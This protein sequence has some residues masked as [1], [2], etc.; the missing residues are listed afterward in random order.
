MP[1]TTQQADHHLRPGDR[2]LTILV[3]LALAASAFACSD[4]AA[5]D[6]VTAN[7][8]RV[9]LETVDVGSDRDG[10]DI[11]V[12]F[13]GDACTAD[14]CGNTQG[15]TC[16]NNIDDDDDGLVECDDDEC[17]DTL[18]CSTCADVVLEGEGVSL[19]GSV[20]NR[21]N[22]RAGSCGGLR[23]DDY[24]LQWT[25]PYAGTW[26]FDTTGSRFNTYLYL[27]DGS[28][29]GEELDCN[30][31]ADSRTLASRIEYEFEAD[32]TVIA[33]VDGN[34]RVGVVTDDFVLSVIPLTAP[35]ET[36]FCNDGVDNDGD[37]GV[38]CQDDDCGDDPNCGPLSRI[39]AIDASTAHT[40]A[41]DRD[42]A[43]WC[44]GHNFASQLGAGGT[45]SR[46][47]PVRAAPDLGFESV[48]V[49]SGVSCG[50]SGGVPWC[51]GSNENRNLVVDAW[52]QRESDPVRIAALAVDAVSPGNT[53]T[54]VQ[55]GGRVQCQGANWNYQARG[56]DS[57]STGYLQMGQITGLTEVDTFEMGSQFGCALAA[58]DVYC[59]GVNS[60]HQVGSAV[61]QRHELA[62]VD[63]LPSNIVDISVGTSHSCA[64]TAEGD[65]WCW[66]DNR[67]G[68]ALGH[69]EGTSSPA[70][71][72]GLPPMVSVSAGSTHTCSIDES[73]D[74][75]CWGDNR[76]GACGQEVDVT[77]NAAAPIEATRVR[78][79]SDIVQVAAGNYF[80]CALT[81]AEDLRCW[82]TNGNGQLGAETNANS[83]QPQ[84]V[85]K[86]R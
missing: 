36:G 55:S 76:H 50:V 81:A 7:C 82:G 63:D 61:I 38:D 84:V 59:W 66:G 68:K 48:A 45:T 72:E 40:C 23:G 11:D 69:G 30:D 25:A 42:G 78:G 6:C 39:V 73:G 27:R 22:Y 65:V 10:G 53:T 21:G 24:A 56:D 79:V 54:C 71:V 74:V 3:S 75:W 52:S 18:L 19:A 62:L 70:R 34:Q 14:V 86:A 77:D 2:I 58:G 80:T 5:E 60:T 12:E 26:R 15:E 57:E 83:W 49:N 51:W 47:R 29:G 16:G 13:D 67:Q 8:P 17:A 37:G 35:D 28:C 41:I 33:V 46:N 32:Q 43:M 20:R 1:P 85:L 64:L 4:D 31:D 9:L 44:W